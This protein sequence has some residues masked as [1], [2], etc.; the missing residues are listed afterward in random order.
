LYAYLFEKGCIEPVRQYFTEQLHLNPGDVL[1]QLQSGDAN[2]MNFVPAAAAAV[3][4]RDKLFGM[5][6][7]AG[8][9]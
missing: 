7:A 8:N 1:R 3:I 6:S 9:P 5:G 4:E 2:W